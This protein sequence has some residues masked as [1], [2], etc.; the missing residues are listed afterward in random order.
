MCGSRDFDYLAK[1]APSGELVSFGRVPGGGP[2]STALIPSVAPLVASGS[3][4]DLAA[5]ALR[6]GL[7]SEARTYLDRLK[8]LGW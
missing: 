4:L 1:Y 2:F 5:A 3:L 8:G 7:A 6:W